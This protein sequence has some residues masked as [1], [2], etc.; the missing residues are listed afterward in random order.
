[1]YKSLKTVSAIIPAA[2]GPH[3]K[4]LSNSN[5]PDCMVPVN[6]KPVIGYIIE[7]LFSRGVTKI[8]VT[9]NP[10]DEYTGKYLQKKFCHKCKLTIIYNHDRHLGLGHSI[11]LA[12]E[13]IESRDKVLVV[14]GDTIY[15]GPLDLK[16]NFLIVSEEYENPEKWC[17]V[18]ENNKKLKF[19]DKPKEYTKKGKVLCG[20]YFFE[21]AGKL[22]N[23][24]KELSEKNG[25]IEMSHILGQYSRERDFSLVD[26]QDW[27]D[28]GNIENY[29]KAKIDFLKIRSFNSLT[30]NDLYGYVT[31]KSDNTTKL[32]EE[33]N[34]YLNI[35]KDL[36]IFMPRLVDCQIQSNTP[37]YSLEF[38]GYQTL[39]DSFLFESIDLPI[40]ETIINRLMEIINLFGE[41]TSVIP[42]EDFYSVYYGKT[43]SRLEE[44][45]KYKYWKNVLA[46]KKIIINGV[47]FQNVPALLPLIE[48]KIQ[49]LVI[50]QHMSFIHGDLFLGNILFDATSKLFKFIDPKGSFGS[51]G[52]YGDTKYD[53]GKLRHS[54]AGKY[55]FIVSDLFTIT[56]DGSSFDFNV[57]SEEYHDSIA[58]YFDKALK[59]NNFDLDNIK[60]IEGLL[61][62]S[63]IPLHSDNFLR[64]QAMY[65]TSIKRLN[66]VLL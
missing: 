37:S 1:M 32:L 8:F 52:I 12:A 43:I 65:C 17:F 59:K 29:Y 39:A 42:V 5:L 41:H 24:T 51:V 21:N 66:E 53:L 3:N 56:D 50:P 63:M 58:T 18:E 10:D 55:D 54:F 49:K 9:L 26:A 15:K 13:K 30:Y 57:F 38:Y 64:Q 62:L 20:I 4:I 48:K 40:W 7:D 6:G 11:L 47:S 22:V 31:K 28:C 34:W 25:S 33:I 14:L 23:I 36:T 44:L 60:L 61:F 16:H 45:K 46:E 27:Y 19:I 2:G 35:P